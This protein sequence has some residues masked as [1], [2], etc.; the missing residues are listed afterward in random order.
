AGNGTASFFGDGGPATN[1]GLHMPEGLA[2]DAAGNLYIGDALNHRIRKVA[3]DGT[4]TTVAG[5]SSTRG[6]AGDGGPAVNATLNYPY[7]VAVDS[8]GNLFIADLGNDSIRMV[9]AL[10][11]VI[12]TIAGNGK[13][14]DLGDG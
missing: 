10:D 2:M 3:S 13:F 9:N 7:G 8:S 1:A 11:G 4:I 12:R 14:G 6:F 5:N